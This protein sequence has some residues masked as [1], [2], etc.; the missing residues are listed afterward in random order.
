MIEREQF[1]AGVNLAAWG[2]VFL[3]FNIVIDGFSLI[4]SFLGY[5]LLLLAIRRLEAGRPDLNRW[6]LPCMVLLI[7]DF[8]EWVGGFNGGLSFSGLFLFNSLIFLLNF[9]L[10]A[11]FL[12]ALIA[13]AADFLPGRSIVRELALWRKWFLGCIAF[14]LLLN[15]ALTAGFSGDLASVLVIGWVLVGIGV[16][17]LLLVTLFRLRKMLQEDKPAAVL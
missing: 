2:Y 3:L 17:I 16:G 11:Y 10:Q 4:P 12:A 8:M 6:Q 5:L 7:Y 1:A 15:L 14:G 13:L 9:F